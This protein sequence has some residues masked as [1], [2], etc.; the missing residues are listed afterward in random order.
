MKALVVARNVPVVEPDAI[1]SEGGTV[2]LAEF[3]LRSIDPPSDPLSVTVQVVEESGLTVAGLQMRELIVVTGAPVAEMPPPLPVMETASPVGKVLRALMT[4]IGS[5][6]PLDRVTD[7]VA[8]T[9]SEIT[10]E[11]YP[12]TMHVTVPAPLAQDI[13]LPADNSAGPAVTLKFATFAVG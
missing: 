13:V 5:A 2:K 1:E 12:H 10:L 4:L 3:E 7:T 8:T 6:L 11:L 9:P